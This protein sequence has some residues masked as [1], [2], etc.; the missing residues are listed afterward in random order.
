MSDN[1]QNVEVDTDIMI[2]LTT[3]QKMC[4]NVKE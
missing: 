3:V 1:V 4:S 2:Q